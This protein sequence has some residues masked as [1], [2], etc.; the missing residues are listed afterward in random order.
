MNAC[1]WVVGERLVQVMKK[2]TKMD[3]PRP[4]V[5]TKD[6][7]CKREIAS[8]SSSEADAQHQLLKACGSWGRVTEVEQ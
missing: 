7:R 6:R 4:V 8:G 5:E 2:C 1:N 3:V